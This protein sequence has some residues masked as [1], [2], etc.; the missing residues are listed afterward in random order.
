MVHGAALLRR[1]FAA[2]GK[3]RRADSLRPSLKNPGPHEILLNFM[4]ESAGTQAEDAAE[5][6]RVY[7]GFLDKEES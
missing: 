4:G 6:K 5:M 7:R 1:K 3:L 2:C